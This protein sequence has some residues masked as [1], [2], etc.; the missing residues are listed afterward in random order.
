MIEALYIHVPFCTT[1][2]YY[3]DFYRSIYNSNVVDTWLTSIAYEIQT[4]Q[5]HPNLKTI[6]IGGGTP[7]SLNVVQLER[8]LQLLEPYSKHVEEYTIESNLEGLDETKLQILSKYG[9]NRISLGVQCFDD[10]LL[11]IMNR[12]HTVQDIKPTIDMIYHYIPNISI[13]LIYGF[14]DQSEAQWI[15]TLHQAVTLDNVSHISIYS[16]TI[17]TNSVFAK[18]GYQSV[19][20]ETESRMYDLAIDLLEQHGF[21][22]YEIANFARFNKQSKHNQGYWRYADFYGIGCGASGKEGN[23]RYRNNATIQAYCNREFSREEEILTKYDQMFEYLMMNLRMVQSFDCQLYETRFECHFS[24]FEQVLTKYQNDVI[25]EYPSL[26]VLRS[27]RMHLHDL[28]VD[29]WE[30]IENERDNHTL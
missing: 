24:M 16:L 9:V 3:C 1:I 10:V 8:F 30:V 21:Q 27:G 20:N 18:K 13:D 6:Y 12:K 25:Y 15:H 29:L 11:K 4:K 17:E 2:C 19:S 7:T 28:L 22:Q 23:I 14:E 5:I 26:Q